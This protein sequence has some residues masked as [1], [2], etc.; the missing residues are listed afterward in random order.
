MKIHLIIFIQ[1]FLLQIRGSFIK[2]LISLS[3]IYVYILG[4]EKFKTLFEFKIVYSI[5]LRLFIIF[6]QM[7]P[8]IYNSKISMFICHGARQ[9]EH[10]VKIITSWPSRLTFSQN[11]PLDI[12]HTACGAWPTQLKHL[13]TTS[14]CSV[15]FR[16]Y[17]FIHHFCSCFKFSTT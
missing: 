9:L 10:Y 15:C 4:K 2:C 12:S 6:D 7:I 14:Y 16:C 8:V 11:I 3:S 5:D 17:E 13:C 1:L